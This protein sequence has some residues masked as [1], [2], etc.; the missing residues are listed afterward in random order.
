MKRCGALSVLT[1]RS[2]TGVPGS[3]GSVLEPVAA[4]QRVSP[5][6]GVRGKRE[7]ER[8]RPGR[9]RAA[10]RPGRR[11]GRAAPRFDRDLV[12]V[13][14]ERPG[15]LGAEAV[16]VAAA[17][18]HRVLGHARDAVLGVRHVDA[19]PV[20]R[21]AAARRPRSRSVTSTR[22]PSRTRS[23]GPGTVPSNVSASTVRPDG[24]C[25]VRARAVS[26][27]RSSGAPPWPGQAREARSRAGRPGRARGPAGTGRRRSRRCR[28]PSRCRS[29]AAGCP[30]TSSPTTRRDRARATPTAAPRSRRTVRRRTGAHGSALAPK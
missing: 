26:V 13:V 11:R 2:R 4:G 16:D 30:T 9:A 20:D 25:T 14:P 24:S 10:R 7:V 27:K 12:R 3:D 23:S 21:D 5:A 29:P 22:S 6:E 1:S 28:S 15:P 19:V 17:R 8:R 18:Q